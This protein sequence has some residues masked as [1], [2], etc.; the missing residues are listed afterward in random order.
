MQKID[1]QISNEVTSL[2]QL[3]KLL[4]GNVESLLHDIISQKNQSLNSRLEILL[5]KYDSH[6]CNLEIMNSKK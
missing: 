5:A 4:R 1:Q 6:I 3:A 2:M